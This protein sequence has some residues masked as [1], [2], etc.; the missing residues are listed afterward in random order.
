MQIKECSKINLEETPAVEKILQGFLNKERSYLKTSYLTRE[1]KF[2][3][4][5]FRLL[6][7]C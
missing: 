1:A 6:K 5:S 2:A 4:A 7:R 3:V